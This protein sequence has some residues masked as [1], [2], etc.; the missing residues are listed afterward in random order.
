MRLDK[1][2]QVSR[3]VK[4]RVLSNQLCDAG[5]VWRN[6]QSAR[7]SAQVQPGDTLR[8]DFGW[9]TIELKV[10]EVPERA[11]ERGRAAELYTIVAER[12]N[13]LDETPGGESSPPGPAGLH[14]GGST[15]SSLS[16]EESTRH[17]P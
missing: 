6:G 5:R 12:R 14:H 17:G 11:V 7:A 3:L 15:E 10:L 9:R 2:L 4:R 1:Y 13:P 8:V 16:R